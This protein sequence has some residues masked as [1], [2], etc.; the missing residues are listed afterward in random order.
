LGG[1]ARLS[2]VWFCFVNST[3]SGFSLL[4][5]SFPHSMCGRVNTGVPMGNNSFRFKMGQF[6]CLAI[7]GGDDGDCNVLLV[8]TGQ[9]HVL[10]DTGVGQDLYPTT[11]LLLDRL[12]A[13]GRS[14]AGIDIVVLS[15]AD[16]DHIG[17]TVDK[18]GNLVFP[19][20]RYVL[21]RA[22]WDFWSSNP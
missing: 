2:P 12:R 16:F 9:Y 18:S 11:A 13:E 20:A 5:K 19:N 21:S 14:P 8:D 1:L 17:G 15:H 3:L 10:I 6:N 4:G 7:R 22:E